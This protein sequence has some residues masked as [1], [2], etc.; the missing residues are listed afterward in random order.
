MTMPDRPEQDEVSILIANLKHDN[1]DVRQEAIRALGESKDARAVEP[2]LNILGEHISPPR[3]ISKVKSRTAIALSKIG[4]K[5]VPALINALTS[6]QDNPETSYWIMDALGMTKDKRAIEPLTKA[7]DSKHRAIRAGA[8]V[9]LGQIGDAQALEP[10]IETFQNL[11]PL[12]GYLYFAAVEALEHIG[13]KRA[14]DVL[15]AA[16]TNLKPESGYYHDVS[17]AIQKIRAKQAL[18]G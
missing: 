10:L 2:L 15:E 6:V 7:L 16:F 11:S 13:G 17:D 5:A 8:I 14:L 4:E 12:Q 18:T 1:Y 9:A 3:L